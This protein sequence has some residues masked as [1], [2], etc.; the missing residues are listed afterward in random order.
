MHAVDTWLSEQRQLRRHWIYIILTNGGFGHVV[1]FRGNVRFSY[2]QPQSGW[3]RLQTWPLMTASQPG[4]GQ[5][6]VSPWPYQASA[7]I[8]FLRFPKTW[9]YL[10]G[11][12]KFSDSSIA[13]PFPFQFFL[14]RG[15][16]LFTK[17][18]KVQQSRNKHSR[19]LQYFIILERT[20]APQSVF[21]L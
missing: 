1:W 10:D 5:T 6:G 12:S 2:R 20:N 8:P 13:G 7:I 16:S 21:V 11:M 14:G 18:P 15:W 19:I 4:R 9:C 3:W 17:L